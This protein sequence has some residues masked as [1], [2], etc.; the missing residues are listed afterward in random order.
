MRSKMYNFS[1][2]PYAKQF[3]TRFKSVRRIRVRNFIR[4]WRYEL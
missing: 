1:N 2:P 4:W 3:H